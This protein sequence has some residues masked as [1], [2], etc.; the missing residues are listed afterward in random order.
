MENVKIDF[1]MMIDGVVSTAFDAIGKTAG[2]HLVFTDGE[3][4]VYRFEI[5]PSEVAITK[6][7]ASATKLTFLENAVT[8]G[9]ITAHGK[10]FALRVKTRKL[11]IGTGNLRVNYDLLDGNIVIS[12]HQMQVNWKPIQ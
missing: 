7:G 8:T 6:S 10:T 12:H 9:S 11:N 5:S 2:S 1:S 4:S 3:G